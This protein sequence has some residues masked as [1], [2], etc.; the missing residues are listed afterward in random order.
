MLNSLNYTIE[1]EKKIINIIRNV[2]CS[3]FLVVIYIL[4]HT[5]SEKI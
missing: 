5:L 1:I 3:V 2:N 4:G